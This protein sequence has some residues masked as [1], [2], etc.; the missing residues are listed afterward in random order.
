MTEEH[1]VSNDNRANNKAAKRV[2]KKS[3]DAD[4]SKTPKDAQDKTAA[5]NRKVVNWMNFFPR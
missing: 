1:Q 2:L 3:T 4:V 5:K